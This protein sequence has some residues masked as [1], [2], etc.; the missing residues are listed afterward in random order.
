MLNLKNYGKKKGETCQSLHSEQLTIGV[1]SSGWWHR[2]YDF[3][4]AFEAFSGFE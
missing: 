1:P 3:L 2:Q 4:A